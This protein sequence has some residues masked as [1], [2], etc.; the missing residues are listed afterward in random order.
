MVSRCDETGEILLLAFRYVAGELAPEEAEAFER[1]LD[2]DQQAR[3]AV[4]EAVAL[5]GAVAAQEPAATVP[6]LPMIRR[7]PRVAFSAALAVA[8][9]ACVAW[10]IVVARGPIRTHDAGTPVARNGEPSAVVTLA[11]ST[12]REECAADPESTVTGET[13][14][15]ALPEVEDASDGGIPLWLLDA[16][17]LSGRRPA[18]GTPVKEL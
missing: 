18:A 6:L 7:R 14:L 2:D 16:A 9:A 10:L 17:S 1:R 5:A 3:E 15:A 12:L 4:A 11:W 8:A 13:E